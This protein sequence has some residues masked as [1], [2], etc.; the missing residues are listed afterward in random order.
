MCHRVGISGDLEL[1]RPDSA[2]GRGETV[3]THTWC[4]ETTDGTSTSGSLP[5]RRER[6]LNI[7]WW[8]IG[9]RLSDWVKFFAQRP[10]YSLESFGVRKGGLKMAGS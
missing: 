3:T 1:A 6:G 4:T 7:C 2:A 5:P 10:Q 8:D 9:Q